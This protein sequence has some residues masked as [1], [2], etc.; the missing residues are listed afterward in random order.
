MSIDILSSVVSL[1]TVREGKLV[2]DQVGR[3]RDEHNT[4]RS[5]TPNILTSL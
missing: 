2:L 4:C 1:L 3:Q 5:L